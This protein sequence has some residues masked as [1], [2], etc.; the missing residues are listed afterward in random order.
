MVSRSAKQGGLGLRDPRTVSVCLLFAGLLLFCATAGAQRGIRNPAPVAATPPAPKDVFGRTTPRGTVL[1]FLLAARNGD[2][3]A[4]TE[5]LDTTLHGDA[6][7]VLA[8]QLFVVLDRGL[9]A[10]LSHLSDRPE[11]SL[12]FLIRPDEDLIGTI[13]SDGGK[14]NIVVQ[15][16]NRENGVPI[17]VFSTRT[18]DAVPRLYEELNAAPGIPKFLA[19][20]RIFQIALFEW[21]VMLVGMPLLYFC[22]V[23]LNRLLSP[24]AGSVIRRIRGRAD[25]T[26]PEVVPAPARLL[27]LALIIRWGLSKLSLPLL[28]REF[29]SSAAT[30]MAIAACVWILILLNGLFENRLRLR[31]ARLKRSGAVSVLRLGRRTVDLVILFAGVLACLHFLGVDPT[32]V[33]AGVGVGGIAIALAAQKTLE[34]VIGGISVVFD[35]TVR[36]G[37]MVKVGDKQGTVEEIGLRSTRI[38]TLDRTVVSVP[39]GQLANVTLE[40]ISI[41]DKFWFHHTVSLRYETSAVAVRAIIDGIEKLVVEIP[42]V[43]LDSV[44]VRFVRFEKS[45]LDVDIVAYLFSDN[46]STFTDTQQHLL[47]DIMDVVEAAGARMAYPSQTLYLA[48]LNASRVSNGDG[49]TAAVDTSAHLQEVR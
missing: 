11:G 31:L 47:L 5:Y 44:M 19:E 42:R 45:S 16:V 26:D 17:W 8:H 37:E 4:A 33:L 15:R 43:D 3:E 35:Q 23:L 10:G 12:A 20:T 49:S 40:N 46:W 30:V 22:T 34:N 21:L 13:A 7:R 38:R 1:G 24:L 32:A 39:N 48:R 29:W 25:L 2:N 18:L 9:P 6:A 41:R 28:A 14:V 27:L 36:V